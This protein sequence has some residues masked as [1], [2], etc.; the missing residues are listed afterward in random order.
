MKD[1]MSL[2]SHLETATRT[3]SHS[4]WVFHNSKPMVAQFAHLAKLA[5]LVHMAQLA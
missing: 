3:T 2:E 4:I 5:Q 1:K